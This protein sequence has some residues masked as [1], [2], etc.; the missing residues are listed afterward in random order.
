[1]A[2][3]GVT[4]S[5]QLLVPFP[6]L[7]PDVTN[8]QGKTYYRHEDFEDIEALCEMD[9][10]RSVG[11]CPKI[12]GTQPGLEI[13]DLATTT[14]DK[15]QFEAARCKIPGRLHGSKGKPRGAI[16][17]AKFKTAV[18][19]SEAE[20]MLFYFHFSRLLGNLGHVQPAAWRTVSARSYRQWARDALA[21][22]IKVPS[23]GF[24][25]VDGWE[26]LDGLLD[27]R[28]RPR[29]RIVSARKRMMVDLTLA[30]GAIVENPRGE[31][32]RRALCLGGSKGLAH[33]SGFR[34]MG[35]YRLVSSRKPLAAQRFDLQT[36]ACARDYTDM[37][38][39]DHVFNQIDR[40]G[41]IH[42]K[43][44]YHSIDD[45]GRL[46]WSG[47]ES[48]GAVPLK[49]LVMKDND[50]GLKWKIRSIISAIGLVD[51]IRHLDP[52]VYARTQWL[53]GLMTDPATRD[54]VKQWFVQ[55]VRVSEGHYDVVRG[56]FLEV[57]DKF[58]KRHD[59]GQLQLDLDLAAAVQGVTTR[60]PPSAPRSA[61]AAPPAR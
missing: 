31:R 4:E 43:T 7:P 58:K 61:S 14:L 18:F 48:P 51:E 24:S 11:V 27:P 53:A 56:R 23:S 41:N 9:L 21:R 60:R 13:Y 2:P 17:A 19:S 12:H 33:P 37:I 3:D 44:Y 35:F 20:S 34:A 57:A 25:T 54:A 28:T 50:D 59:S 26:I 45:Q 55:S 36:L 10:H 22:Q 8:Y 1:V 6:F 49:R 32:E 39:L 38:I 16:K 47:K 29:P 52:T 30:W 42:Q 40:M 15:R 5:C 46:T